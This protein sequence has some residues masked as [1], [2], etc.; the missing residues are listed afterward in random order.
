[1][2]APWK[3]R[4]HVRGSGPLRAQAGVAREPCSAAGLQEALEA[5]RGLLARS[6]PSAAAGGVR[7][8]LVV[9]GLPELA[10]LSV[11]SHPSPGLEEVTN[12]D[13]HHIIVTLMI[14]VMITIQS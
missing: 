11:S 8:R 5:A 3:S 1:M 6:G 12:D 13:C 2:E 14:L 4:G 9:Y 7:L 10:A